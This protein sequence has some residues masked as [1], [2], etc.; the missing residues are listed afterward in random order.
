MNIAVWIVSG[1]LAVLYLAVGM[2]KLVVPKRK[3]A[4][5]PNLAFAAGLPSAL[6]LFI[7]LVEVLGAIGV[8]VPWLVGVAAVLTPLAAAGLVLL[9]IG[10]IVFHGQRRE[11][12]QWPV[13]F[14]LAG[15]AAFVAYERFLELAA[16]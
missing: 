2:V 1:I 13:N 12:K 4:A 11:F 14:V 3:M 8:I 10:A 5:N 16:Q 9:Q 6:I 15:L 7:G